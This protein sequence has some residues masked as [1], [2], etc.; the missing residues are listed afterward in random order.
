MVM[1][2]GLIFYLS[3]LPFFFYTYAEEL[4]KA[5]FFTEASAL[6]W[7]AQESG[8][9][10]A[11]KSPSNVRLAPHSSIKNPDFE[12]DF[13][14]KFEI[15][16]RIPHDHWELGLEFTSLQTH[17]DADH[18]AKNS[19]VFF[20]IWEKPISNT[21]HFAK[22]VK[23]HWRLHLG[24][25]DACLNHTFYATD[26]LSLTPQIA[27]RTGWIRQ[28]FNLEYLGGNFPEGEDL[29]IRMKN[30]YWGIGPKAGLAGK[31]KIIKGFSLFAE[32]AATLL[33]GEFYLHQDEDTLGTK[34]KL[35]GIH[36]IFRSS[37]P[38]L[39]AAAGLRWES[40]FSG[41]FN[42]L[43]LELAWDQMLF[44]SQNQL[45]HFLDENSQGLFASNQADLS[46]AGVQLAI[47]L[48][49]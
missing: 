36:H 35:L 1:I 15:G 34:E 18:H 14:F 24:L 22:S 32:G 7:K 43:K 30:K 8:L 45:M 41:R 31:W 26:S 28:K 29:L 27:I 37:A 19:D 39:E 5:G 3:T 16:Y 42:R 17:T 9:S 46:I 11:I 25:I 12:W 38:I 20:P 40:F 48:D 2:K 23:M 21:T 44:F 47:R 33:F 13:G 10:Y 49:F 6:Y 4:R